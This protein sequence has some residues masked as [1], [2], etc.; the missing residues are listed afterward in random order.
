MNDFLF[1]YA[2]ARQ[3]GQEQDKAF[4]DNPEKKAAMRDIRQ[5]KSQRHGKT[6]LVIFA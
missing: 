5:G 1:N 4:Y 6:C 2:Q 3:Q